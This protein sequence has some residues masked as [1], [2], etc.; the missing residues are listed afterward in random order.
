[1]SCISPSLFDKRSLGVVVM[2]VQPMA[3]A[4]MAMQY[5]MAM[6]P[7]GVGTVEAWAEYVRLEEARLTPLPLAMVMAM[8]RKT[9]VL[10]AVSPGLGMMPGRVMIPADCAVSQYSLS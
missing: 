8:W 5:M 1:M 9:A 10:M 2:V 3:V 4:L 7:R 6:A